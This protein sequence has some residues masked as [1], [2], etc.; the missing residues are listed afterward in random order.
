LRRAA[1]PRRRVGLRHPARRGGHLP[2]GPGRGRG[3]APHAGR[4]GRG[5]RRDGR[6]GRR[7]QGAR[8]PGGG[9]RAGRGG[10]AGTRGA[11]RGRRP[12]GWAV[13]SVTTPPP[14]TF[15]A[16]DALVTNFHLPR[17]SLLL[18]VAAFTGLGSLKAAYRT[19]V[20]HEYRFYSY[21]D[22]MLVI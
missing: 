14:Y 16:V 21:G 15:R 8:P 12:P 9:A 10:R 20:E 1:P 19:A 2:A 6:G 22:A 11:R 18:L 17:S 7:L 4:V 3:A 5:A 13:P